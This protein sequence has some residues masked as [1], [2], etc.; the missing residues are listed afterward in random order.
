MIYIPIIQSKKENKYIVTHFVRGG[1]CVRMDMGKFLLNKIVTVTDV[2][3]VL[4]N[5]FCWRDTVC[6]VTFY[7]LGILFFL[8]EFNLVKTM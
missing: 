4:V 3:A 6:S 7:Q 1:N 8:S 2:C 5:M